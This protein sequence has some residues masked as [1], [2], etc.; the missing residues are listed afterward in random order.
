MKIREIQ[1]KEFRS[2]L[3]ISFE[4]L[5]NLVVFI[6]ENGTG[7]TNIVEILNLFFHDFSSTGGDTSPTLKDH[8]SWY[9]RRTNAPIEVAI[10]I[11]LND[12]ECRAIF[13]SENLLT[14]IK[15]K[16]GEGYRKLRICRKVIESGAPWVTKSIKWADLDLV[17]DDRFT[18]PEQLSKL[19]LPKEIPPTV[20]AYFFHGP[21]KQP[22]FTK[23]RV[24]VMGDKAY[25]MDSFT[26][27][28]VRDKK[29]DYEIVT[30]VD[31]KA[32]I[33][34]KGRTLI[35]RPPT[36]EEAAKFPLT[37]II[38][39]EQIQKIG[40]EIQNSLKGRF[41]LI[42][43]N[44]DVKAIPAKREPFIDRETV[45]DPFCNLPESDD[46]TMDEKLTEIKNKIKKFVPYDLDLARSRLRVWEHGLRID[47]GNVGGG[48]QEIIGLMWQIY[49]SV[50]GSIVV[51]EE[52]ETHLH[53]KLSRELFSLL[54]EESN[55]RQIMISTHSTIFIDQ[56]EI[57]NN[58]L[59][60]KKNRKTMVKRLQKKEELTN[61]LNALGA[62]PIDRL[63]P[64]KVLLACE[65]E[66]VLLQN[67]AKN[68][69]YK[70]N[71]V[72][73]PLYSDFDK[74]KV[75]LIAEFLRG[76]QTPLILVTDIHGQGMAEEAKENNWVRSENCFVLKPTIE[77]YY[78]K[79]L[80]VKVLGELYGVTVKEEEIQSPTVEAIQQ[81]KEVL[82]GWKIPVALEIAN[83]WKDNIHPDIIRI[84]E[85]LRV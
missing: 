62:R 84:F 39:A 36:I 60:W 10:T 44:R 13:Q 59:V 24:I 12:G 65:T 38:T 56:D 16:F 23:P 71:G 21:A 55:K 31:F 47:V 78:P 66:R 14:T 17:K 28:L 75:R 74:H 70:I 57:K 20:K 4:D 27:S 63:F 25:G 79:D 73:S 58:W 33:S 26:E 81:I 9:G 3:K 83:Q 32:W 82:K 46:P 42:P 77:D 8:S 49:S 35:A 15:E 34:K 18:S 45:I 40:V 72:L 52:P 50:E 80:L 51:I 48:Q 6:G 76:T 22:D 41:I 30:D 61:I 37:P 19:L 11:E 5:G 1:I 85:K 43:S 69:G 68:I 67:L 53:P 2:L 7:K 64:N 54:K 29:V